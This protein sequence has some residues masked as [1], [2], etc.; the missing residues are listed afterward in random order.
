MSPIQSVSLRGAR[1][2]NDADASLACCVSW[3]IP[4]HPG[5]IKLEI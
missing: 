5:A 3:D 2:P 4:D 1:S